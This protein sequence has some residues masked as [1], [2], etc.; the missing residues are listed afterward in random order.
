MYRSASTARRRRKVPTTIV[1][2]LVDMSWVWFLGLV[3]RGM[4][5]LVIVKGL[6][7]RQRRES[8]IARRALQ[9]F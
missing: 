2:I 3:I 4:M 9:D 1:A 5:D 6:A 8:Q 7:E